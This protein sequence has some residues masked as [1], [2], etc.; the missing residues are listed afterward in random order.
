[1]AKE[2]KSA[3]AARQAAASAR[4]AAEADLRAR[5]RKIRLIGGGVV[6]LIMAGLLAIPLLQGRADGPDTNAS[7]ALPKGVTSDTYGV[8]V[9]TG[10]TAPNADSIPL[11]QLWEDFQCPACKALEETTGSTILELAQAG[12]IRLEYRPTIFLDENL[13]ALNTAA[14]NPDSSLYATMAL[15]CAADQDKAAEFHKFVFQ[16][17]PANE[18]DGF[19]VSDLTAMA[20]LAGVADTATFTECLS[21]KKYE[22][23]VNNSYDAFSREGVSATPTAFLNGKELTNDVIRD[24]AALTAAIEEAAATK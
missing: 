23:W 15:G 13:K 18:G 9:G 14:G 19:S 16:A 3:K 8:K 1:M 17:Q 22:G 21:S 6:A 20:G 4:A 12:K 24:V 7:A 11:F 5:D 10:W 2:N